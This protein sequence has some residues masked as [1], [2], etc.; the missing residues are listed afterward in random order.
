MTPLRQRMIQDLQ[1]HGY[2]QT[3]QKSY[4]AAVKALAGYHNRSPDQLDQEQV[5]EYFL[6]LIEKKKASKSTVTQQLCG[7]NSSTKTHLEKSSGSW[8]W[9]ARKGVKSC[10]SS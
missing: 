2:A 8:I 4:V 6:N 7:I 10:R 1:L 5:R 3:T 9:C